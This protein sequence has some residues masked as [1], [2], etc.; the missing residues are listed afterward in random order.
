VLPP[1]SPQQ[2][3]R[4]PLHH[5]ALNNHVDAAKVLIARGALVDARDTVSLNPRTQGEKAQCTWQLGPGDA[6]V[7]VCLQKLLAC[8]K[9]EI[10]EKNVAFCSKDSSV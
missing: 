5:A 2:F 8:K 4:T 1:C 6:R 10:K 7:F 3:Q 9:K